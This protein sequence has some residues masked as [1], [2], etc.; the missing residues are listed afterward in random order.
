MTMHMHISVT[1][2][3]CPCAT[4]V[5]CGPHGSRL[6]LKHSGRSTRRDCCRL[7][8]IP[9][10][11]SEHDEICI[12]ANEGCKKHEQDVVRMG[13]DRTI[14][15][16]GEREPPPSLELQRT[17]FLV[18]VSR[19]CRRAERANSHFPWNRS[20]ECQPYPCQC[21]KPPTTT[22]QPT[23]R[24]QSQQARQPCDR[25]GHSSR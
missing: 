12:E 15:L 3:L 18:H 9:E 19:T 8:R 14:A 13:K 5:P 21:G 2:C 6:P 7:A 10:P 16:V 4:H 25:S 11:R 20:L 22:K 23:Y 24:R 17:R 1:P